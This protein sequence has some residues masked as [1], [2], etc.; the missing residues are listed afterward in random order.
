MSGHPTGMVAVSAVA[1]GDAER[2]GPAAA[3]PVRGQTRPSFREVYEVH[4][5]YVW[6]AAR[7]LGIP[8]HGLDDVAQDVFV[9][10]FRRLGD[11]EGRSKLET[12]LYGIAIRVVRDHRR[13]ARRKPLHSLGDAEPP[14][15]RAVSPED[16]ASSREGA[17]ILY[18]LLDTLPEE[19]REVFVMTEIEQMTAPEIA[20]ALDLNVNTVYARLRTA[21]QAFEDAVRQ[22]RSGTRGSD[23]E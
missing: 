20:E 11:F 7:R 18:A 19:K 15:A 17:R 1:T 4:F 10:V 13:R 14:D 2:D 3:E 12:W 5:D 6:H 8:E 23:D 16:A 9:T 21:R 22:H